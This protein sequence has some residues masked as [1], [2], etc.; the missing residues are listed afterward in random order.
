MILMKGQD[1]LVLMKLLLLDGR[2]FQVHALAKELAISPSEL[3]KSIH[4]CIFAGLLDP[5]ERKCNRGA[6]LEFMLHGFPYVFP[7]KPGELTRGIPTA[8]S[9]P[10]LKEKILSKIDYVWPFPEGT[11]RGQAIRPIY[12]S[13]PLAAM[14]DPPLYRLLSLADALRAGLTRERSIASEIFK[15]MVL[16]GD[17]WT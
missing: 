1:I 11:G 10:P 6:F 9:A 8:H 5:I 14:K 2:K 15:D 17:S 16:K 3:S 12:K 4:R 7:V 13:V